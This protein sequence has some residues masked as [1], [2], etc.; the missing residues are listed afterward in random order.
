MWDFLLY[1]IVV[2]EFLSVSIHDC[3]KCLSTKKP[4]NSYLYIN[5]DNPET[6]EETSGAK[7]RGDGETGYG[8]CRE[9]NSLRTF[10]VYS[11]TFSVR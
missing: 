4:T 10:T 9:V 6:E 1:N 7:I 11:C 5:C 3:V 2:R 8:S